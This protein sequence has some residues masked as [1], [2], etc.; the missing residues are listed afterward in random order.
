MIFAKTRP[1]MA[2]RRPGWL[3]AGVLCL[4]LGTI[5][6][7]VPLLPTVD[8]YG[9]AAFCFARGDRRWEAW[10]LAH[11]RLGPPIQA[12]RESRVVPLSAKCAATLSMGLSCTAAA[13]WLPGMMAWVP[14]AC[15]LPVF[16]Y[17]W[18][19]PSWAA[20]QPCKN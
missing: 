2:T 20:A 19:R 13:F 8:M 10:L 11:P 17:L 18:T 14:L 5:G 3:A 6:I 12:W 4:A 16:A 1:T 15:C 7:V 9:L